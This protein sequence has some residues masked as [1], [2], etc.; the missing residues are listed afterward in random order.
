MITTPN[1]C[2]ILA[3]AFPSLGIVASDDDPRSCCTHDADEMRRTPWPHPG[4]GAKN[5]VACSGDRIEHIG[6]SDLLLNAA[7]TA[8]FGKMTRLRN[9]TIVDCGLTGLIPHEL[10]SL[11]KLHVLNLYRN[12]LTGR[13]PRELGKLSNLYILILAANSLHGP[14]PSTLENIAGLELLWVEDNFLNG[15]VPY[16]I[17]SHHE[18]VLGQKSKAVCDMFYR[19]LEEGFSDSHHMRLASTSHARP[20]IAVDPAATVSPYSLVFAAAGVAILAL[21]VALF[22]RRHQ[23]ERA[24]RLG[25]YLAVLDDEEEVRKVLVVH[26]ARAEQERDAKTGLC[27]EIKAWV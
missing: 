13:I 26:D 2:Q 27:V 20:T 3:N 4:W 1:D 6:L 12:K 14:I 23:R 22:W 19:E 21:L 25:Q 17:W 7:I 24:E 9:L 11:E 8:D 15:K 10:G 18:K 5:L 16:K